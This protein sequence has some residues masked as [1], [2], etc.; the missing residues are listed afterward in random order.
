MARFFGANS[1]T[2]LLENSKLHQNSK[3]LSYSIDRLENVGVLQ[4][5]ICQTT[6]MITKV[7]DVKL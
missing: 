3:M 6:D 5:I 7:T 4:M 1:E 2:K